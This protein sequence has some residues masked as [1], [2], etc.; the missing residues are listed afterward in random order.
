MKPVLLLS[1][2]LATALAGCAMFTSWKSIPP[3]GGCD[4]CHTVEISTN[5]RVA[6]KPA[7]VADERGRQAFQT[8]E[9]NMEPRGKEPSP[10]ETK[11]L[12]ELRCFECHRSPTPAHK[13]RMGRFH[14]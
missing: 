11:K 8:P 3:P 5:W 14:H 6:Y 4:Q 10:L 7:T 1:T 12:R 13:G 2:V 9:Y